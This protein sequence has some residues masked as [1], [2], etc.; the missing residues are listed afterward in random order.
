MFE[1]Y[2]KNKDGEQKVL[3]GALIKRGDFLWIR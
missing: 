1:I 2:T 3:R